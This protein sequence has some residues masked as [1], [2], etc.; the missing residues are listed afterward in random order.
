MKNT[1][2]WQFSRAIAMVTLADRKKRRQCI[3][4]L[5]VFILGYFA[6]G[7]WVFDS[8]LM[9]G[10]LRMSLYWGFLL[11]QCV[12]LVLG[13]VYDALAVIG[14]ERRKLGLGVPLEDELAGDDE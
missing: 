2:W 10:L 14:E 5:L 12:M 4:G 8:W 13:A 9:Q 1:E 3:T 6:M 11:V 7:I